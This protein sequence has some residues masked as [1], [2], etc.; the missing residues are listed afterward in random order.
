MVENGKK[1]APTSF[2]T[3][4]R[5]YLQAFALCSKLAT[6]LLADEGPRTVLAVMETVL[7][8]HVLGG[9]F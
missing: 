3:H 4:Y 9:E 8:Q 7:P 5:V 1:S 2:I 6:L